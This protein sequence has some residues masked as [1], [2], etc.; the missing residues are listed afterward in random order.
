LD[1][2]RFLST[3]FSKQWERITT[4]RRAGICVPLFS[5][6]SRKS[7]GIGEF[8]DLKI[9][10][11]WC[12]ENGFSIIQLLPLND[13]GQ[14]FAPYNSASSFAL[15]PV[16]LSV[17]SIKNINKNL[18]T[19]DLDIIK[20]L[21]SCNSDY[22]NYGIKSAKLEILKKYYLNRKTDS[23]KKF[24]RFK[25]NNLHWL[26]DYVLFKVLKF[27]FGNKCWEDWDKEFKYHD[28]N[29]LLNLEINYHDVIE[30]YYWLQWQTY[31]QLKCIKI[32]AEKKGVKILGDLPYL[33]SRD[34][35]DV[36]ANQK[37]FK[38]NLSSG[39]PPD[40]YFHKGQRWGMPPYNWEEIEKDNFTYLKEKFHYAENFYD[41]FRIDHFVGLLRVWTISLDTPESE[42]GL[43]G[44]FD[45]AEEHLWKFNAEKILNVISECTQML[46][47][48][49]DLG[50]VPD[51]SYELLREYG[52]P[53]IEIQRWKKHWEGNNE[54]IS[55]PEYRSNSVSSVSTHDS[56]FFPAWWKYETDAKE[57]KQFFRFIE[58]PQD[59]T[60]E[61]NQEI[62]EKGLFNSANSN[63]IFNIESL[64]EYLFLDEEILNEK[65]N[66]E[67]RINLPGTVNY[68][69]WSLRIPI[70]LEKLKNHPVNAVIKKL[71]QESGRENKK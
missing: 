11:D 55:P 71:I 28:E 27:K 59:S 22:V 2:N 3:K 32:Y 8:R 42:C 41:M 29:A 50:T 15:D 48:A 49:E 35:A 56:S 19:N 70:S 7:T 54:F 4:V 23:E 45:P 44:I 61:I 67:F 31:M 1:Y 18:Y 38:L 37:Y 21:F 51:S 12:C 26:K 65:A 14:D 57:K 63:S 9:I 5:I 60:E 16:Y 69:N 47:C 62:I 33:V 25:E 53:G 17:S 30:F 46:P 66:P 13:T 40:M 24:R 34:S 68:K 39:A 58:L 10:I 64:F 36:W 6:H 52:I 43:T 20:K